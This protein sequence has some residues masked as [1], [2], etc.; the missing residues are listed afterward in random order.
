MAILTCLDIINYVWSLRRKRHRY[1]IVGRL[2]KPIVATPITLPEKFEPTPKRNEEPIYLESDE[3]EA[4][5]R[6]DLKKNVF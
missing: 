2:P 6:V 4:L 3:V 5:R 1:G